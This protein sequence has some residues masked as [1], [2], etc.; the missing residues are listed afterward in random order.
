MLRTKLIAIL[1]ILIPNFAHSKKFA[2]IEGLSGKALQG[3]VILDGLFSQKLSNEEEIQISKDAL[4]LIEA[5][6]EINHP[7]ASFLLGLLYFEESPR[8]CSFYNTLFDIWSD[9]YYDPDW[10]MPDVQNLE[11]NIEDPLDFGLM[12]IPKSPLSYVEYCIDNALDNFTKAA[13]LDYVEAMYYLGQIYSSSYK[14]NRELAEKYYCKAAVHGNADACSAL[15][16]EYFFGGNLFDYDFEKA[17]KWLTKA[18]ELGDISDKTCLYLGYCYEKGHGVKQDV[19]KAVEIYSMSSKSW[20]I[21]NILGM[22]VSNFS[23]PFRLGI[24]YYT[25]NEVRDYDKAFPYLKWIGEQN[26]REVGDIRGFALRCL[27]AC[28]RF[29][30]GTAIDP[31]KADFYLKLA[32]EFGNIDAQ[33]AL[34]YLSID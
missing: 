15:G 23:I 9:S 27:S 31:E 3:A 8:Y 14:F 7:A 32:G 34:K 10:G 33:Q 4:A 16:S 24:L 19:R 20:Q 6:A 12:D 30:R 29:G 2:D 17:V 11:E 22:S 26:I 28:Y 13:E 18:V 1:F 5:D 21:E 25:N